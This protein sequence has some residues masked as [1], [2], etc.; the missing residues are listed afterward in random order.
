MDYFRARDGVLRRRWCQETNDLRVCFLESCSSSASNLRRATGDNHLLRITHSQ[1]LRGRWKFRIANNWDLSSEVTGTVDRATRITWRASL[2]TGPV[3]SGS[4][5][6]RCYWNS[7]LKKRSSAQQNTAGRKA[8]R[9]LH[10]VV[11]CWCGRALRPCTI[12]VHQQA[13]PNAQCGLGEAYHR[14]TD[15]RLLRTGRSSLS[16]HY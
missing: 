1:D 8:R 2:P 5:R 12:S 15:A 3:G 10:F 4:P 14:G 7:R 11:S 13:R 6:R 9:Q 16:R